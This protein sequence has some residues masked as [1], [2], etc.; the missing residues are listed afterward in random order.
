MPFW[1]RIAHKEIQMPHGIKRISILSGV[2]VMATL[3]VMLGT[4]ANAAL[5][6]ATVPTFQLRARVTSC[7]G[8]APEGKT[9]SFLLAW[10]EQ[11]N[12]TGNAWS[13]WLSFGPKQIE[14]ALKR[15]PNLY[16]KQYPMV[17]TLTVG[18]VVDPTLVEIETRLQEDGPVSAF[19]A[20]LFGARLGLLVW[21]D[22]EQLPHVSTV[23]D[24]NQRYWKVFNTVAIPAAERPK[25][26]PICD[27]FDGY[28]D[29]RQGWV[30]GLAHLG[31][32]GFTALMIPAE[33]RYRE[34]LLQAGL[35]R[36]TG[37]IY[38]PPGY[39]FDFVAQP[40]SKMPAGWTG[41]PGSTTPAAIDQWAHER[42]DPYLKA[43]YKPED[44]AMYAMSDEPGWYFPMWTD[45]LQ[46][47]ATGM[48]HFRDY[49][50]ARGLTPAAVG[51]KS[52][53][54]VQPLNRSKAVDLPSR[55]LFYWTVRFLA[56]DSARHFANSVRAMEKAGCPNMPIFTNWGYIDRVYFPGCYGNNQDKTSP[57]A[58]SGGH[59]WL[60]FGR[61]RGGTML[62]TEDWCSDA[63]APIWSYYSAILRCAAE[64]GG[65]QFG[66]YIVP[67]TAGDRPD[68][69]LQRIL[70]LIGSGGKGLEYFTFGPEYTF[71]INCYS[72]N[73][74]V[75]PKIAEAHRMIGKAED[76]LWPGTRPRTP[77]AMLYP[78]SAQM[79]DAKDVPDTN[80]HLN[81]LTVDYMAE[82]YNLYVALQHADIP[83]DF[84]E[85]D[86]LSLK[87]L[88]PYKVLYV[89]EPNIPA[90]FQQG[91]LAWVRKG[92][93][94]VT[95]TGAGTADRYND[96]CDLLAKG[97]GI[98]EQ[99]RERLYISST[100]A[101]PDTGT[102]SGPLGNFTAFGPR[103]T[104]V[105]VPKKG[106]LASFADG[107]PAMIERKVDNGRVV[108]F[109]WTPGLSYLRSSSTTKDKL[110]AGF[111]TAIR[112]MI[113]YPVQAA[114]IVSPVVVDQAMIET[115]LL[116][117]A[118]GAAV[119][120][121]NWSGEALP[122]VTMT[123][124]VPFTV[125]SVESVKQ[126]K[127]AFTRTPQG[128]VCTLPL[129]AADIVML[130]P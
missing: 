52:W 71:P 111:S 82:T 35:H 93:T 114:K 32:A 88:Q 51:A 15:Y 105:S 129:S 4:A 73:L 83:V 122:Q 8:K 107:S 1:A 77:V 86:D 14:D 58:A 29:E 91:L 78:R 13:G 74:Q 17:T 46:E 85:E 121:L 48:Q 27:M 63:E 104:L 97:L 12:V 95:V 62:W 90:E 31:Q 47:D 92:G 2:A 40:G 67:R 64:K 102:G 126:G 65:V 123:V 21:R 26:F 9:F 116:L 98:A 30:D 25:L 110:P 6:A 101:L 55:R 3:L 84:V 42:I 43:G 57:D 41:K 80:R 127:L 124:R 94:V 76:L 112:K 16:L 38:N 24:Y 115:P 119:T 50:K 5:D 118:K 49:L 130:R 23:A 53:E 39:A 19:T 34:M 7:A 79:W 36:T 45:M 89:T 72:E 113:I 109:T 70:T 99:P 100:T 117:S 60:E 75:L 125:Q 69:M 108:H 22:K 59:D 28:G 33:P 81:S 87:G 103:G 120:L 20:D 18:G 37:G 56:W 68:G 96:P 61:M 106:V 66:G 11:A 44:I 10:A 128:I 54:Q